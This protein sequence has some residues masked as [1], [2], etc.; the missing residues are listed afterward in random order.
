[1]ISLYEIY[2]KGKTIEIESSLKWW[3][4]GWEW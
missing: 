3:T 2:K 4:R 1:M